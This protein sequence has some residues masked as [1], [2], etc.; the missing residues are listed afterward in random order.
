M[1]VRAVRQAPT[2]PP[3]EKVVVELTVDEARL[4]VTDVLMTGQMH[5]HL[6]FSYVARMID[7]AFTTS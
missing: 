2:P 5:E 1:E 6:T 7:D 3:V 4:F